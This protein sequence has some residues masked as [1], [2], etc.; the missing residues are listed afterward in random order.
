MSG[1]RFS[2]WLYR[3]LVVP[4]GNRPARRRLAG[5]A[6]LIVVVMVPLVLALIFMDGMM[7]GIMDKYILLQDGHI[8]LFHPEPLFDDPEKASVIDPRIL[9]ADYVVE[10]YGIVYSRDATAEIRIKG[11]DESYFNDRR[12]EQL[13]FTEGSFAK[14]GSL[15][16]VTLS[17]TVARQLGVGVGDRVAFMVVPDTSV[18]VV[19]PVLATVVSLFDSGYHELD[20]SL[21]FMDRDDALKLFPAKTNARTEIIVSPDGAD[22]LQELLQVIESTLGQ[23]FPYATWDEFNRTVYQNF[24]TS[25]QVILLVFLMIL[26]VAGVYVASV[27]QEMVQDSMQSIALFKT[28]GATGKQLLRAY[29]LAVTTVVV[30]GMVAGIGIGLLLGSQLGWFLSLLSKSGI[31]GLQY[32]LLDFSVVVSWGDIG[33]ICAAMLVISGVSV[34]LALR[35]ISRISPLEMLQQD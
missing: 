15:A 9:S 27:A 12:R 5:S 34:R 25:R 22:H 18:A 35:R 21:V 10:G 24:I 32:Y 4:Q 7:G 3:H 23:T 26:L 13:T 29:Y 14:T 8:Q 6:L 1:K 30:T 33:S 16:R 17:Q 31:A 2:V 28:L 20:S 19:R 11:I